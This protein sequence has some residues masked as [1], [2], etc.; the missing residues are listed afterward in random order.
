MTEDDGYDADAAGED[1]ETGAGCVTKS[2]PPARVTAGLDAMSRSNERR[3]RIRMSS[4][5]G[6]S[7]FASITC[8]RQTPSTVQ[9]AAI[10]T[11]LQEFSDSLRFAASGMGDPLIFRV[12]KV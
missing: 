10:H 8:A 4:L 3:V 12:S 9:L 11:V 5:R 2:R 6:V 1:D 7:L